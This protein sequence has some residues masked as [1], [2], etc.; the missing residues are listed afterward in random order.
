MIALTNSTTAF[1]NYVQTRYKGKVHR[2]ERLFSAT[3]YGTLIV[4]VEFRIPEDEAD[5][6]EMY[7]RINKVIEVI[8]EG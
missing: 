5:E 2:M 8:A 6:I 1:A 7:K 4:Q 3:E